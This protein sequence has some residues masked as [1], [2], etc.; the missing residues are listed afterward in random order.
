ML[1]KGWQARSACYTGCSVGAW[2]SLV[3][4]SVRDREAAGSNPVAPTISLLPFPSTFCWYV[5]RAAVPRHNLQIAI[6]NVT[7]LRLPTGQGRRMVERG[8][9]RK[10]RK[11]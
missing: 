9:A 6:G 11:A 4:R 2:L 3:E 8:S 1:Y 7:Q 10:V 5:P